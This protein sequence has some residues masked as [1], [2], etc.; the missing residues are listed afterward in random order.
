MGKELAALPKRLHTAHRT[1]RWTSPMVACTYT[2]LR[3]FYSVKIPT[4]HG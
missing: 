1:T 3:D 2:P 4:S